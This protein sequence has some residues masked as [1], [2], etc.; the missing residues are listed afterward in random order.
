MYYACLKL[1]EL[2]V[3]Q[4]YPIVHFTCYLPFPNLHISISY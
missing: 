4:L 1:I 2:E 3:W